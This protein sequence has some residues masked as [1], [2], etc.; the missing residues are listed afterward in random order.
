MRTTA[1]VIA[2]VLATALTLALLYDVR[3]VLVWMGIAAFFTIALVPLVTWVQR[4]ITRGRRLVAVVLVFVVGALIVAGLLA[5]FAVPLATEATRFAAQLPQL[6]S[7]ARTG[8]GLVGRLLA[9]THA[10]TYV[11]EHQD[12][13]SAFVT[14]LTT[15]AAGILQGLAVG[16]IGLITVVVLTV[17]GVLEA[18]KIVDGALN[19]V[20]D[21]QRRARIRRV[22]ADCARSI[23]GY[24]TGNLAISVLCGVLIFVTLE[25]LGVPFAGLIALFVAVVDLVPIVGATLGGLVAL[26]AAGIHSTPAL[27][28]VAIFLVAYQQLENHVLQPVVFARTVKLNPLA[29]LVA[30]LFGVELAG[31]LGALLG[32]PVAGI[33]QVIVRDLW[34]RRRGTVRS[35]PTVGESHTPATGHA[36]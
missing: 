9:R 30:I 8:H 23:T 20:G 27:I 36:R 2:M 34:D 19:L 35:V 11:Q 4:R 25:I 15:P 33:I 24:I 5:V 13:I 17:L 16:V 21:D 1:T 32:I 28:T 14:G 6:I 3:R 26:V 31:V 18:P 12:R 7:D 22:A 10:L 29:V